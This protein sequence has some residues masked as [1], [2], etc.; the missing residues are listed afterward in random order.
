[1]VFSLFLFHNGCRLVNADGG[2]FRPF[3]REQVK[4]FSSSTVKLIPH[5]SSFVPSE[6]KEP[7]TPQKS[8]R[9]EIF[10]DDR[11]LQKVPVGEPPHLGSDGVRHG[12]ADTEPHMQLSGDA[13]HSSLSLLSSCDGGKESCNT[14]ATIETRKPSVDHHNELQGSAGHHSPMCS[15]SMSMSFYWGYEAVIL[16]PSLRTTGPWSFALCCVCLFV[17]ASLSSW[18]NVLKMFVEDYGGG[19]VD[20]DTANHP[21][22]ESCEVRDKPESQPHHTTTT[23]TIVGSV[24][25]EVQ[26]LNPLPHGGKSVGVGGEWIAAAPLLDLG[27]VEVRDRIMIPQSYRQQTVTAASYTTAKLTSSVAFA[28]IAL[29]VVS[30]VVVTV[31]WALMLIAMT[32][33]AGFFIAIVT[34]YAT[35]RVVFSP[36]FYGSYTPSYHF[37]DGKRMGMGRGCMCGEE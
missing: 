31:H 22:V 1:M 12:A 8:R 11:G 23:G 28:T 10:G 26:N 6:E 13:V 25:N 27:Y 17:M 4:G 33:N 35:G 37:G 19:A 15:M 7:R 3:H 14:S 29:W 34:G 32:F 2:P 20:K 36:L 21:T 16:F 18:L 30:L 9:E 5:E 24:K